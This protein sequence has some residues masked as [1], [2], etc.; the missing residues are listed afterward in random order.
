MTKRVTASDVPP[1]IND[2]FLIRELL[3]HG[4]GSHDVEQN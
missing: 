4:H 3:R 2:E 1:F